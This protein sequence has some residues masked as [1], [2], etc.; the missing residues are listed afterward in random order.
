MLYYE[1]REGVPRDE[2]KMM[3]WYTKS[4]E[5]GFAIAQYNLGLCYSKG[6]GVDKD[7]KQ[8]LI[9]I[10]NRRNKEMQMLNLF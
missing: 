4:A 6:E 5:Q 3:E 9:G 10:Q 8:A 1:G 7:L 2:K